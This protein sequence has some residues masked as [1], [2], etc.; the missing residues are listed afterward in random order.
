MKPLKTIRQASEEIFF[1]SKS[2]EIWEV[3]SLSLD[4]WFHMCDDRCEVCRST[5]CVF[6]E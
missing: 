1:C 3:W 5:P 6:K 2:I 4:N